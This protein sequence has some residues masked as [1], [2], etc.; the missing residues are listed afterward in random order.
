[1]DTKLIRGKKGKKYE[2]NK[3]AEFLVILGSADTYRKVNGSLK[4]YE[5]DYL[6]NKNRES[7]Y[8]KNQK[9]GNQIISQEIKGKNF[10]FIKCKTKRLYRYPKNSKK[11]DKNLVVYFEYL[12][13]KIADE[14]VLKEIAIKHI[15]LLDTCD[16]EAR[17][18]N[19]CLNHILGGQY[20]RLVFIATQQ[21]EVETSIFQKNVKEKARRILEALEKVE[22]FREITGAC[23]ARRV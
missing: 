7:Y 17:F 8:Y 12:I 21:R 2:E 10:F 13:G 3:M 4:G 16:T 22:E 19:A 6:K 9:L 11:I 23:R 15:L 14:D 18:H 5:E 1:M 20:R